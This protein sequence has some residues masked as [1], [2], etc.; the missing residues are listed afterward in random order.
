[1]NSESYLQTFQTISII[2]L[3]YGSYKYASNFRLKI[4]SV[5]NDQ[6]S[7]SIIHK[8]LTQ[9]ARTSIDNKNRFCFVLFSLS[10]PTRMLCVP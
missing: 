4:A 6:T 3:F 5:K 2:V 10:Q 9:A 8:S 1:M 7:A